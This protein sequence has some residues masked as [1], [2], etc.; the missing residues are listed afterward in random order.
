MV[1]KV[2]QNSIL[3]EYFVLHYNIKHFCICSAFIGLELGYSV[4]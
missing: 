1:L 4:Q 2:E 3:M